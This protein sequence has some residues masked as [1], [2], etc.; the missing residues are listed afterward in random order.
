MLDVVTHSDFRQGLHHCRAVVAAQFRSLRRLARFWVFA[1]LG[2]AVIAAAYVYYSYIQNRMPD[3]D[4]TILPRFA[5]PYFASYILWFFMAAVVFVSFDARGQDERERIGEALDSRPFSNLV[6]LGGRLFATVAAILVVLVTALLLIQIS[7][8]VGR[9]MGWAGHPLEGV[10]A[11]M[12]LL[13]DSIPAL[14]LWGAI[15]AFLA[16][17]VPNRLVVAVTAL[18]LLGAHM[19]CYA[20]VPAYLLPAVSLHYIHDNWAS[21]LAPRFPEAPTVL[22]RTSMLLLAAAFVAWAAASYRRPDGGSSR[23]RWLSGAVFAI[24]GVAGFATVVARCVDQFQLRGTWLVAHEA[25][26]GQAIPLL[27]HVAGDVDID[28]G[29]ELR[30]DLELL[31]ETPSQ[32]DLDVLLFSFN[33][34]LRVAALWLDDRETPFRHESGLLTVEPTMPLSSGSPASLKLS[35]SGIP[36]PDFAYLDSAVDWRAE[37]ARNQILWLGTAASIFERRYVALMPGLRWLPAPGPNLTGASQGHFPTIDLTVDVPDGWLVA[38]PGRRVANADGRFRFRPPAPVSQVALLAAR[39]E[40]RM[41][42]LED[43]EFEVLLHPGH[44]KNLRVLAD[45]VEPLRSR[46]ASLV[47]EPAHLGIAYPYDGFSVVEVPAHLQA[48]GGGWR[49]DTV[50]E[51]PGMLLLKEP[52]FPYVNFA[53]FGDRG[54]PEMLAMMVELGLSMDENSSHVLR[55]VARNLVSFQTSASGPGALALD[56]VCQ[57]LGQALLA[58]PSLVLPIDGSFTAHVRD[59]E[60]GF[61]VTVTGMAETL[62]APVSPDWNG[63]RYSLDYSDPLVWQR[64]IGA[65]LTGMDMERDP[66]RAMEAHTLRGDA[67]AN[68]ILDSLGHER[69]AMLLATLRHHHTGAAYD[70]DDLAAALAEVGADPD[71]LLGDWLNDAALPG[72]I[73]SPAQTVR[74]ADDDGAPRYETRVSVRNDEPVAGLIRVTPR[75]TGRSTEPIRIPG[76]TSVDIGVVTARP[77]IRLW[78][79]PYLSRNRTSVPVALDDDID[80][81]NPL[82]REPFV[83]VEPSSWMPEHPRGIVIDDLDGGF[84][85]ETRGDPANLKP[86][87][88]ADAGPD[89]RQLDQGLPTY[90]RTPGEWSRTTLG[91]SWGKYR[92]TV[93]GAVAGDGSQVA[94]FAAELPQPGRWQLGYHL[95]NPAP[96]VQGVPRA[97]GSLGSYGMTLVADGKRTPITFDGAAAEPGWNKVGEFEFGSTTVRLEISSRT[98]GEMVIADAIRWAPLD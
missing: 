94:V 12:L 70:A 24:L 84:T 20:F 29:R 39:F 82:D 28:P 71:R 46:L 87:H 76:N 5:T 45:I 85:V 80:E 22:Q 3:L 68:A 42:E 9:A 81:E 90:T 96:D 36:D 37:L 44:L 50:L 78:V 8:T 79:E 62:L 48:Y 40:R 11:A 61:G 98:D 58:N 14:T 72:F 7:A 10:M 83:G 66:R 15:V 97:Y 74:V 4:A 23:R 27:R 18:A 34:G 31:I 77:P 25:A 19:W 89:Q 49:L 41:I 86:W 52:G 26:S 60:A 57:K 88:A 63:F 75:F 54:T 33:P 55:G 69:T 6:L 51:L 59:I 17:V 53:R 21:D 65:S 16:V 73:A 93:A 92:H 43:V 67:A 30:L 91:S 47:N 56:H 95:P 13:V 38:G 35:A 2:I 1:F 32:Q 64:V